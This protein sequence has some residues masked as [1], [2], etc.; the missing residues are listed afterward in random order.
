MGAVTAVSRAFGFL[1]VLVI[2]AVLGTTYLG[3]AFQ[4]ANS[5]SNVLFEL[6][7]AGALSA[8]L[9]PTFVQLLDK[10][11]DAEAN[12][13]ASGLLGVALVGLG[14]VTLVGIIAAPLLAR[15]LTAGVEN[16]AIAAQ[17]RALE[18]YLLRW[19]LP[20]L[21]LYACG[22][23]AT[24]V[25]YARRRFAI[26][27]AA[28]IGN[29][30]V[31]VAALIAFHVVAGSEPTLVLSSTEQL[32]LVIAGTGGVIAFVAVLVVA[33]RRS[34]FSMRPRWN[35]ADPEIR[36]LL[37][38]S[39]WGVLLHANAGILLGAVLVVGSSVAGGVVAYQVAFVFFL[40]PYAV[41]AQ[42]ILT[43]FLPDLV[44]E[45]ERR[46]MHAFTA[47]V[48]D[49]LDRMAVLVLPVSA[50]MIALALPMMRVVAFG[51]A[52]GTGVDLLAAA[53]ASLAIGLFPYGAFLLLSRVYYA[54]GD[55]RTPALVAAV[56]AVV[57]VA[58]MVIG[59]YLTDG[60]A[61]VA[62]LGVGHTAAFCV[63]ALVL[64]FDVHRRVATRVWDVVLLRAIGV[65]VV[66]GAAAWF[67]SD[68]IDPHDRLASLVTVF[69]GGAVALGVFVAGA[70]LAR[71]PLITRAAA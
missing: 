3:N 51:R 52:E 41:L 21:L 6:V 44:G 28:P 23:I 45:V 11:D 19:F 68:V 20:Q 4:A 31:M 63:G 32:L 2:A 5:V 26:T 49:A 62:A 48:R 43:A 27:A 47:T 16:D 46:D 56:C 29:T 18:T 66:A 60:T 59:A 37:R 24:G 38:L 64:G 70:R 17:Q 1:R 69:V 53:L 15:L 54:L 61:R 65:A 7:A 10:G 13:L 22:A 39:A 34:G 42:P 30:V 33:A 14:V 8:V 58:V 71:L 55:S 67:V 57:G 50:V 35:P 36:H 12:R 9:V 40:A 25:L